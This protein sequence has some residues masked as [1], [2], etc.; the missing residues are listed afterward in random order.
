MEGVYQSLQSGAKTA[1]Q[2]NRNY[3]QGHT[4]KLGIHAAKQK[5]NLPMQRLK[6]TNLFDL[7][8]VAGGL[9]QCPHD[10]LLANR[11]RIMLAANGTINM[12]AELVCIVPLQSSLCFDRTPS[13]R[14]MLLH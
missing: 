10:G 11:M 2:L 5:R 3:W 9:C 13:A 1:S 8:L 14:A 7:Q 12:A 6:T 4:A